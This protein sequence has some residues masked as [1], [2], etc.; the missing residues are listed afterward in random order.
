MGLSFS[1]Q[2]DSH[3]TSVVSGATN[4]VILDRDGV[5]N[6]DSDAYIRSVAEFQPL[7]GSIEAIARLKRAGYR[8]AVAT[9]QSGVGRGYCDS[10]A[11]EAMHAR[12]NE[13]VSA[14]CQMPIDLIVYCPHRPEDHCDCRKPEPGLLLRIEAELKTSIANVPFIGDSIRD[15]QAARR[16]GAR[17]ILVR[18]GKGRAAETQLEQANLTSVPVFD[19]LAAAVADIL[20]A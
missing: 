2:R 12:L 19:D 3:T 9:N 15:L 13:L 14:Q 6:R 18:T 16:V 20:S 4:L 10:K 5:I 1:E 11:L 17:P 8:V 7:P